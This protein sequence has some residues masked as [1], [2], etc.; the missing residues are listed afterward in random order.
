MDNLIF[1]NLGNGVN[2]PVEDVEI[3]KFVSNNVTKFIGFGGQSKDTTFH[4]DVM[5]YDFNDNT[6]YELQNATIKKVGEGLYNI[7]SE[8]VK[9]FDDDVMIKGE[10]IIE[11]Y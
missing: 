11:Y 8:T 9:N 5:C 6:C 1:L 2:I 7:I 3:V 10:E 4:K